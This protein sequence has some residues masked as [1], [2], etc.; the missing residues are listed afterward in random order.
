[1][2]NRGR[3]RVSEAE[4]ANRGRGRVSE[5]LANRGRDRV[6]ERVVNKGEAKWRIGEGGWNRGRE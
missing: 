6:S 4:V 1:M 5:R 2:V 3:G